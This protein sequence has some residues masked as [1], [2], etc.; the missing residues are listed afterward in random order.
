MQLLKP[1]CDQIIIS[2]EYPQ[3]DDLDSYVFCL[4][5]R[6]RAQQMF[7]DYQDISTYCVE[8]KLGTGASIVDAKYTELLSAGV[9]SKYV[10]LNEIGEVPNNVLDKSVCAFLNKYPDMVEY[11]LISD[12]YVGLKTLA[13]DDPSSSQNPSSNGS[14]ANE[15]LSSGIPKSRS[16]L[17]LCL[18]VGGRGLGTTV[19]DMERMQPAI[20][21]AIYL[22]DKAPHIR[23]SKEAK[24]KALK[25]RKDIAEQYLKLTHKQRQ[26]AAMLRKEEKR[27]AEKEKIMNES[28]PEKQKKLEEK[29]LKRE[30]KKTLSKMKQIKIKAM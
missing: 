24:V 30:K 3:Q 17:V 11:L 12:Q 13:G 22:A 9:M 15:T 16:I 20:Q 6:K 29:E 18:N 2:V 25:K 21:L 14:P 26:E 8:K 27:R 10:M 5:N 19:E 1:Q 28:D 4:C 7:A 23:L